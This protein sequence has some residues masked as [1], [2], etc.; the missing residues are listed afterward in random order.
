MDAMSDGVGAKNKRRIAERLLAV[1]A[2]V[3]L[4][5]DDKKML[6]VLRKAVA[7]ELKNVRRS[8]AV[9]AENDREQL[10]E[11]ARELLDVLR[12]LIGCVKAPAY[13]QLRQRL[14]AAEKSLRDMLGQGDT[15]VTY[16]EAACTV[17]DGGA[18]YSGGVITSADEP[19]KKAPG[20]AV[21]ERA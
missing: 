13:K 11:V 17:S 7:L 15:F 14:D 6:G 16:E 18:V 5:V 8:R 4:Y 12:K 1:S 21:S 20:D 9:I 10:E 19:P 3:K 2:P